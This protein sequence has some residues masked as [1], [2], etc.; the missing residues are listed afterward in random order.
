MHIDDVVVGG[1]AA[2]TSPAPL[3]RHHPSLPCIS[4]SD[5]TIWKRPT[6]FSDD[7]NIKKNNTHAQPAA[8]AA[9]TC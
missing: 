8:Y 4:T 6:L 5:V 1:I 9:T 2:V 3:P 7:N